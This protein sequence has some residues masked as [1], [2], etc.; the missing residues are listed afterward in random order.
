MCKNKGHLKIVLLPSTHITTSVNLQ[1]KKNRQSI[2]VAWLFNLFYV[3]YTFWQNILKLRL[4]KKISCACDILKL[5]VF[6]QVKIILSF[7]LWHFTDINWCPLLQQSVCLFSL[8]LLNAVMG[9]S[10]FSLPKYKND[11][12][13]KLT[14]DGPDFQSV[15]KDKDDISQFPYVEFTGRDSV[16]CPTCQGTGRIPRGKKKC[17]YFLTGIN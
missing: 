12:Q 5:H 17:Q 7:I 6:S 2:I 4:S 3:T 10:I 14:S 13:E 15:E 16:T 11:S 8:S 9:K 1:K